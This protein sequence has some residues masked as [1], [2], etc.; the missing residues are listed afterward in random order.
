MARKTIGSAILETLTGRSLSP[1]QGMNDGPY[2]FMQG[3]YGSDFRSKNRL[4]AYQGVVFSCTSLIGEALGGEYEPYVEQRKGDKWVRIEHP[5][6][7]LVN[8]PAGKNADSESFSKFDLF[9]ATGIYQVLQGD[10]YWY[11]AKGKRTGEPRELILLR[12]DKVGVDIDKNTGNVNGYF[13]RREG[14]DPIPLEKEEVLRFKMFNPSDPYKGKSSVEAGAEYIETDEQTSR[15]TAN[16]FGNNAG[17]SGILNIKGE[18]TQE[19]IQKVC[20]CLAPE[21]RGRRQRR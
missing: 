13:I 10:A 6:I 7:N 3:R 12:P 9:E 14:A 18:V 15:Y 19:C 16:F 20:P 5:F 4:K 21:V 1:N 17:L 11:V 8:Q 2:A